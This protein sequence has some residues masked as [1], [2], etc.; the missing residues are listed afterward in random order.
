VYH[1]KID[2][3]AMPKSGNWKEFE[4]TKTVVAEKLVFN[5]N[6]IVN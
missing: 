1:Y 5:E 6:Q 3:F 2:I 4:P